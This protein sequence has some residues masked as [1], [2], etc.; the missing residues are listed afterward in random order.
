M[1]HLW[2]RLEGDE[3]EQEWSNV[4]RCKKGGGREENDIEDARAAVVAIL[5]MYRHEIV[6]I[7]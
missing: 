5:M 1:P 6:S 2:R 3:D 4:E 7:S